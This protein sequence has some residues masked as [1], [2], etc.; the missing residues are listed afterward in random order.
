VVEAARTPVD[1]PRLSA[2]AAGLDPDRVADLVARAEREVDAGTIGSCQ[3]AVARHGRLGAVAA[4]G[5]V[6]QAGVTR[7]ATP[8]TLYVAFSC[9]KGVMSAASW[10]LMQDGLLDPAERVAE[11]VPE[12]A[13]NGKETVTVEHLL[14]HT[15]GFPAAP[16]PPEEWP[17][18]AK[19][20]ARFASWRLDWEP[21][22]R[23]TYHPTATMWVLAE[24]FERR[25]GIEH[26]RLVRERV[27][28]P[29]G[30]T[31]LHLGAPPAVHGRIADVEYRGTEPSDEERAAVGYP[32]IP[33]DPALAEASMLGMNQPFAREVGIPGGGAVTN[34]AS[35]AMLYQALLRDG[36]APGGAPVWR[37]E[38][39][40]E[41]LRVRTGD[42]TDPWF[43]TTANRA[44][45]V[46]I[47]G[48]EAGR[49]ARGFGR[50]SS[51]V[52]FGHN[53]AGGQ[54]AWGDPATGISF[55]FLT[56]TFD[57]NPIRQGR[58]GLALSSRAAAC[59]A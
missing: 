57:R 55:A 29:L 16:F 8:E 38:T 23:F 33:A 44:L 32:L 49:A 50:T 13:A 59:A 52:A 11:I 53:G 24:V 12:F 46:V 18:R 40:A 26:R 1:G 48:D 30:L 39:L 7:P 19:R 45:G 2:A 3:L 31:D 58:R 37:P 43:G 15:A 14:C 17:D 9:T 56:N 6:M 10:L 51:A 28:M 25:T 27:A 54:V 20:L 5:R 35:L 4:I 47:A 34:A 22:S 21:G 36:R 41:A 42:L